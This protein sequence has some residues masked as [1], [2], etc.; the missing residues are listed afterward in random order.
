MPVTWHEERGGNR[1]GSEH[2]RAW[3]WRVCCVVLFFSK[4][5]IHILD[6]LKVKF[7]VIFKKK[8][9]HV[10][11]FIFIFKFANLIHPYHFRVT[12]LSF[13]GPIN[14]CLGVSINQPF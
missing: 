13:M 14:V 12:F 5:K 8:F 1:F 4:I 7:Y 3:A 10:F 6:I 2:V 9:L 11:I